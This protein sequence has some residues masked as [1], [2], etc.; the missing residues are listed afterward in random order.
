MDQNLRHVVNTIHS[1]N[2]DCTLEDIE[3]KMAK[4]ITVL[5]DNEWNDRLGE[6]ELDFREL[7]RNGGKSK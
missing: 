4:D 6:R 2:P 7:I 5:R 1:Q 3:Q